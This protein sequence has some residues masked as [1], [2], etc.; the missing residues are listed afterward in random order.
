M[1]AQHFL[2]DKFRSFIKR[3]LQPVL[4]RFQNWYLS[5]PRWYNYQGVQVKILPS[6]FHPGYLLSTKILL[7]YLLQFDLL[8]KK[9]LELG[10]GSG[11]IS[12]FAARNGAVVTASDIN[13]LAIES[14]QTSLE[15]NKLN[16]SLL[17]SD[18]FQNIPIQIFDFVLINPPYYPK[19]PQNFQEM[20]F[21]CG[22]NFEYFE[23]LFQQMGDYMNEHS[24][25]LMILS[26]D[27][28]TDK[29]TAIAS[30]NHFE[31]NVVHKTKALGELNFIFE[32]RRSYH[33]REME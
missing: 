3:I 26:E 2:K 10:A 15:K 12:L 27:C 21:F 19:T 25:V 11:M 14:I 23:K 6:V 4:S 29:I 28:D 20:A 5:K 18:L 13:P 30:I 8:D 7:K 32:I 16:G 17:L 24:K 9:V 22:A 31:L 33:I 1:M